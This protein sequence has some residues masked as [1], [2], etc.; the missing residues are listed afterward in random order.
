MTEIKVLLVDSQ[1]SKFCD[2]LEEFLNAESVA[3][4]RVISTE[5]PK[6]A[7]EL[8]RD[9]DVAVIELDL[10]REAAEHGRGDLPTPEEVH[11]GYKLLA[12]TKKNFSRVKV[13]ILASLAACA[14]ES[15]ETERQRALKKG[16]SGFLCKPV[17]LQTLVDEIIKLSAAGEGGQKRYK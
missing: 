6:A 13:L 12:Y 3:E 17:P 7:L 10:T 1:A 11:T 4:Y 14:P 15:L 2:V 8:L 16:A 9:A 5:E